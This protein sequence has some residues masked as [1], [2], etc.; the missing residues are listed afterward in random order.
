MPNQ[1]ADGKIAHHF[2]RIEVNHHFLPKSLISVHVSKASLTSQCPWKGAA[3]YYTLSADGKKSAKA[4]WSYPK[5]PAT[6]ERAS[7]P[8]IARRACFPGFLVAST[9]SVEV[10]YLSVIVVDVVN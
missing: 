3:Q 7:G 9:Q 5:P 8:P 1:V 2:I 6:A 4:A 10:A